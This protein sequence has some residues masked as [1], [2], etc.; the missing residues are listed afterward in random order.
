MPSL[1]KVV[2]GP[3]PD[4]LMLHEPFHDGWLLALRDERARLSRAEVAPASRQVQ[5]IVLRLKQGLVL[6][7]PLNLSEGDF[8]LMFIVVQVFGVD[9]WN[10]QVYL[11]L[12]FLLVELSD[13][14]QRGSFVREIRSRPHVQLIVILENRFVLIPAWFCCL[15]SI[16]CVLACATG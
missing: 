9:D 4:L 8:N 11:L 1:R 13:P 14:M 5:V 3:A 15:R 7:V 12:R 16:I 2:Y 10:A 6:R